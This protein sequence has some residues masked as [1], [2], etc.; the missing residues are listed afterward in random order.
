MSKTT[1]PNRPTHALFMVEGEGDNANW[2]EIG[3]LWP[4]ADGNGFNLD[5]KAVPLGGRLVIRTRKAK[6][7]SGKE[8]D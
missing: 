6:E 8:V 7:Q 3:A 5:L 2:T 1:K 4:H